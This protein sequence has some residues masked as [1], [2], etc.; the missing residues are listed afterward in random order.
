MRISKQHVHLV[1][2]YE[3]MYIVISYEAEPV[4]APSRASASFTQ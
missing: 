4:T 1:I 2:S 3:A